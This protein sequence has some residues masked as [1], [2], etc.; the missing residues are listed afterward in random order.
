MRETISVMVDRVRRLTPNPAKTTPL[1]DADFRHIVDALPLGVTIKDADGNIVYSNPADAALHGY[2]RQDL[3]GQPARE[4]GVSTH[5]GEAT[6]PGVPP[7][8]WLRSSW[9]TRANGEAFPVQLRSNVIHDQTG[10]VMG[11][12]TTCEDLAERERIEGKAGRRMLEDQL[13]G[14]ANRTFLVELIKHAISRL[15]RHTDYRFAILYLNLRRFRVI[16]ETLG[17]DAG[18]RVLVEW[19]NRVRDAIR[20]NDAAAR[21][22][23]DEFAILL[24]GLAS[25]TDATRVAERI[26]E[27]CQRPVKLGERDVH[28]GACLGIAVSK[29]SDKTA[30]QYLLDAQSA[31]HRAQA[32]DST[33]AMFDPEVHR[34][35]LQRLQL[36]TDLRT[37]I[38]T[39]QLRAVYQ[40]IVDLTTR[41][42]VGFE[43]LARWEHPE[44]GSIP[45]KDFIPVAEDTGLVVPIGTW[46]LKQACSQL[47][48]W[49]KRYPELPLSVNVNM[50]VRHLRRPDLVDQVTRVLKDTNIP[51]ERLKLEV[52]ESMLMEDADQQ[53]KILRKLR[54]AGIGVAID[55]FGTGYSSLSY[56]QRFPIDSLKIDR[57]FVAHDDG[58]ER[59][60]IVRLILALARDKRVLAVAE[61][62][63]ARSQDKALRDLGCDRAQGFLYAPPLEAA[64]AEQVLS[65]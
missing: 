15:G 47:A 48:A 13:T 55:D 26:I 60:D 64:M 35:A 6:D 10:N 32:E 51:P 28:L 19:A 38:D 50:S 65:A 20:P 42:L 61:G 27:K 41:R 33:Y 63:E 16:N 54:D 21:I 9:N 56:L 62:V 2:D 52:T 12:V 17:H 34:R 8:T 43:A 57:S 29:N 5:R 59:W 18:D 31:M 44:R 24:D 1:T 4:F 37:A 30:D 53:V 36:E 58:E 3:V 25:V 45:P 11:V 7:G 40:P 46:M 14:L 49:L 22:A 39:N 23:A